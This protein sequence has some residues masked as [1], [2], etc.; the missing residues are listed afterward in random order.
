MRLF[1]NL[2]KSSKTLTEKLLEEVSDIDIYCSFSGID[3][4]I[5]KPISSPL[6]DDDNTPSF[7]LFIPTKIRDPRPEEV[8]WRDFAGGSG[9]VFKFVKQFASFHYNLELKTRKDIIKFIDDELELGMFGKIKKPRE[10]HFIDY[11]KVKE[12]KEILFKSREFTRLDL[13]WWINYGIDK[14]LLKMHDV[15]SI[16]HLIDE[17]FTIKYTFKTYDLAFAYIIQDKVKIYCPYSVTFKWRNTCPFDY[18]IGEKQAIRNDVL[19]ITKS[20]KDIL[21]FKTFINCDSIAPQAESVEFTPKVIGALK[22]RYK[23]IFVVMDYDT[24]GITAAMNLEKCGFKV[25]WVSKEQ[26]LINGKLKV[27]DKDISDYTKNKGIVAGLK[28]VKAMFSELEENSFRNS[29]IEYLLKLQIELS[30]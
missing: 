16:L 12:S 22:A 13:F 20:M 19:I 29:R 9:S 25:R 26:V 10:K 23:H 18:I 14:E 24:A 27:K 5:G 30:Q 7:S 8:W 2:V 21:V 4:E 11:D 3:L 17:D 28:R 6:R 15:R 1:E